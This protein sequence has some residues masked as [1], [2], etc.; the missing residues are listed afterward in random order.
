M[1]LK[2]KLANFEV[3]IH[4]SQYLSQTSLTDWWSMVSLA[5]QIWKVFEGHRICEK[6]LW[7]RNISWRWGDIMIKAFHNNMG[8]WMRMTM[9]RWELRRMTIG[10]YL[11]R[12]SLFEIHGLRISLFISTHKKEEWMR[13]HKWSDYLWWE[14][15]GID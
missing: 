8:K 3:S 6:Q 1:V 7:L 10:I 11:F 13:K 9:N 12:K 2:R 4:K 14:S 15:E 5:F